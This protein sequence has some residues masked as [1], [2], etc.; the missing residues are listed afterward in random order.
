MLTGAFFIYSSAIV[1]DTIRLNNALNFQRYKVV[2]LSMKTYAMTI[3][4]KRARSKALNFILLIVSLFFFST[5]QAERLS[6]SAITLPAD[7]ENIYVKKIASD[8]N[9]SDFVIFIKKQVPLHKHL[10]HTETIFVLEGRGMFQQGEEKMEIGPGDYL[11]IPENTPHAVTVLS[12]EA[13][14]VLSVQ[15]PEFLGKDRVFIE[16]TTIK[17]PAIKTTE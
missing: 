6:L 11:R 1:S 17:P 12:T 7:T 5:L 16:T 3:K 10:T 15:A 2:K 14:K 13:L 4:T 9:S 8:A